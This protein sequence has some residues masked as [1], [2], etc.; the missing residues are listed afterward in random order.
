MNAFSH[1]EEVMPA[2]GTSVV[3]VQPNESS[4][5]LKARFITAVERDSACFG[6]E[7]DGFALRR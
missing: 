6:F 2:V 5:V 4:S 1:S 3:N 7:P